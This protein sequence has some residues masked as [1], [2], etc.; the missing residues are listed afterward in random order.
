MKRWIAAL[1]AL[2]IPA[3]AMAQAETPDRSDTPMQRNV[4]TPAATSSRT[5]P[6]TPADTKKMRQSLEAA[7]YTDVKDLNQTANGWTARA[8]R[9]GQVHHVEIGPGGKVTATPIDGELEEGL[10]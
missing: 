5:S 3:I 1:V 9:D 8:T 6:A 2:S 7:G 10:R 4:D